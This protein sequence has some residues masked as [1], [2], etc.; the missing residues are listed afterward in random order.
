MA[1][2]IPV[3]VGEL[4]DTA[5]INTWARG[6]LRKTTSKTVNTTTTATDLLNGEFTLPAGALST[7]KIMRLTAWGDWKQNTAAPAKDVPR[8]QVILGGTTIIDTGNF[9]TA[10]VAQDASRYAWRIQW[11]F[12]NLASTNTQ[13]AYFRGVLAYLKAAAGNIDAPFTT[14]NGF[15]YTRDLSLGGYTTYEGNALS[16]TN[17]TGVD[18]TASCALLLKVINGNN[19]AN[20]ETKLYGA[21]VEII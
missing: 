15:I 12:Q 11:E 7:D 19:G 3:T 9:G 4:V 1:T 5:T 10:V 8:F 20:Y 6:Y 21:L 2:G 13:Q 14:G 17:F 16:G 18:T